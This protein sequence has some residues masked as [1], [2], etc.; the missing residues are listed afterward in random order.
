[1][2]LTARSQSLILFEF[3]RRLGSFSP[4]LERAS[5]PFSHPERAL[6]VRRSIGRRG[7]DRDFDLC[8]DRADLIDQ[9]VEGSWL[10][11]IT[12]EDYCD[13][14]PKARIPQKTRT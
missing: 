3:D 11:H 5:P 7:E 10:L 9:G 14:R 6:H 1:M 12:Q 8:L 4:S 13:P 2:R